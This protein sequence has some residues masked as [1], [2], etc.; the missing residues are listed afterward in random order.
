M[1]SD[2]TSGR[3]DLIRSHHLLALVAAGK[4][5]AQPEVQRAA[6]LLLEE[7]ALPIPFN[8]AATLACGGTIGPKSS[9]TNLTR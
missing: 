1:A 4:A 2:G 9:D 3:G 6:R 8:A 5:L 7:P